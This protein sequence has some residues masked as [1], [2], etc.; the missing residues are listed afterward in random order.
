M[1]INKKYIKYILSTWIIVREMKFTSKLYKSYYYLQK[2]I[3]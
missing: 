2:Y 1:L 3:S